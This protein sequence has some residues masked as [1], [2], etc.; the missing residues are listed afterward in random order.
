[1]RPMTNASDDTPL[2]IVVRLFRV[3]WD[4]ERKE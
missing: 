2:R 3:W 1:M 4:I